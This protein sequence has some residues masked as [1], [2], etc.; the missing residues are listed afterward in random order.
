M[1]IADEEEMAALYLT[2]RNMIPLHNIIIEMGC[3]QPQTPIQTDNYI[4]V[5]FTNK[6]SSTKPPNQRI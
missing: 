3:P 5:G 1:A 2:A 4:A 6:K